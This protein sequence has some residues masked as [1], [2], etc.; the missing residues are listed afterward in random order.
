M[1]DSEKAEVLTLK[2]L[3]TAQSTIADC[4]T[5]FASVGKRNTPLKV[6]SGGVLWIVVPLDNTSQGVVA[7]PVDP[8]VSHLCPVFLCQPL[9]QAFPVRLHKKGV[10]VAPN[11]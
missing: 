9:L 2:E 11:G 6:D 1:N 7:A 4:L 3:I 10:L 8:N 5:V